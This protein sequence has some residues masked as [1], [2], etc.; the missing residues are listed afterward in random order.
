MMKKSFILPA[1]LLIVFTTTSYAQEDIFGIDTKPGGFSKKSN[2]GVGNVVRNAVSL[3]SVEIGGGGSYHTNL[4]NFNSEIPSEYPIGQFRNID[5][6]AE[7]TSEDTAMFR[8]ADYAFPV[9]LGIRLNLFNT[10]ILGGGYGRE[11]GTMP[12]LQDGDFQFNLES[13]KYVFDKFYGTVGLVL[14]DAGKRAKFL[15]WRYRRY[16]SQ[17]TYMQ[18]EKNQRIRQNYPWRFIAEADFGNMIIRQSPDP[19]L[20]TSDQPFYSVG[21]RIERDFSEYARLFFKTGAEFR[22]F[23]FQSEN[24]S[25]FQ[26][27]RQTLYTAQ[28][29]ISISLPGTKRCKVPGCGVVMKHL[30]DG[31]EHRGSSIFRL[32]NRRVGQWY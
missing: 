29:G 9:H 31:V 7:I 16:A 21:L 15:G 8:G 10:I 23:T 5:M 1:L 12:L 4:I 17:N 2:S 32:Q 26:N 11:F 18:S 24:I 3:F 20:L 13:N 30:H 28:V 14:Y 22:D 6:P 25:E 19:R 27:L